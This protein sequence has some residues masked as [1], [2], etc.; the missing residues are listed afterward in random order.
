MWNQK[1]V[2]S[3]LPQAQKTV[4]WNDRVSPVNDCQYA[5]V[6]ALFHAAQATRLPGAQV[7]LSGSSPEITQTLVH[8]GADL[9]MITRSNL[10]QAFMYAPGWAEGR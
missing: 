8:I 5:V 1:R 7:I 2:A 3:T 9:S 6:G 4:C 10:Y